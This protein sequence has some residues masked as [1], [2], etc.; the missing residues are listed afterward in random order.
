MPLKLFPTHFRLVLDEGERGAL[1]RLW[2]HNPAFDGEVDLLHAALR[3][4][5]V[6]LTRATK[7]RQP[8]PTR[9]QLEANKHAKAQSVS[10]KG[11]R[12]E[13]FPTPSEH[14]HVENYV[15]LP[16]GERLRQK[17]EDF[18]GDHPDL[19]DETGLALLL[20]LGL[21]N[22]DKE[23][24]LIDPT[25]ALA[26]PNSALTR[27]TTAARQRRLLRLSQIRALARGH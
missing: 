20:N 24:E 12:R 18:L 14:R 1:E 8:E 13:P 3:Q 25:K 23:P 6:A 10:Q 5:I 11:L 15:G 2:E 4:G 7:D 22:A 26:D 19:D 21:R 17:I 9:T 16:I 27:S